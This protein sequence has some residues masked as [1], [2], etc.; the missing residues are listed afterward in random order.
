MEDRRRQSNKRSRRATP[1]RRVFMI[2]L[3]GLFLLA[4]V[5][6]AFYVVKFAPTSER[7]DAA[8][9]FGISGDEAA[10]MI[11]G[12]RIV[13]GE[14]ESAVG[15]IPDGT[16]YVRIDVIKDYMDDGYVYDETE[17]ILRYATDSEIITAEK[18]SAQYT[19][20]REVMDLTAP[21]VIE[22]DATYISCEFIKIFTPAVFESYD[23]PNRIV[24]Q[25]DDFDPRYGSLDR[26]TAVRRLGG[27]KSPVIRDGK[28]DEIVWILEEYGKWTQIATYDGY[29]GC[30]RAN[31][32][33]EDIAVDRVTSGLPQRT[34]NHITMDNQ[35]CLL[36]HQVTNRTANSSIGSVLTQIKGVDVISPTWFAV[37][38]TSGEITDLASLDYVNACHGRGIQVW[39]LVDDFTNESLDIG[40][41]LSVTS[42]RDNLVNNI[43]A[44][45][46]AYSL[47]GINID[48]EKIPGSAADGYIQFIR[49]LSIKCENNDLV[50][51]VDNYPPR[52]YSMYY[53]RSE[54]A[55]YADYVIVMAYDEHYSTSEEAGSNSSL[56]YVEDAVEQ[57]LSEV[58][59]EQLVLALPFYMREFITGSEGITSKA[60]GMKELNSYIQNHGLEPQWLDDMGQ[61]Y[62]EFK[63]DEGLHQLWIEDST[64]LARKLTIAKDEE[65]AGVAFWKEGFEDTTIWDVVTGYIN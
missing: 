33:V 4:I 25:T 40:A 21:I 19:V 30:V 14:G 26:N 51:S 63:D 48:F 28:R 56:P 64:S 8:A 49:E 27:P 62:T 22:E 41:T 6:T 60:F 18:D 3:A 29:V 58:P 2:L 16:P 59:K 1:D 45:A 57:T 11:D 54:Q 9:Y 50:L 35:V 12:N 42:S 65:L 47:D 15:L 39:G 43:V 23:D 34:Y 61:N 44:K 13:A 24:F 10:V 7:V 5:G 17:H 36:W 53:N 38:G 46:I 31:R 37:T 32:L 20:G 55:K 52:E